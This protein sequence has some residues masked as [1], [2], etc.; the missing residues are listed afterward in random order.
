MHDYVLTTARLVLRCYEPGDVDD[1][2][3][4]ARDPEWSRYLDPIVPSPYSRQDAEEWVASQLSDEQADGIPFVLVLDGVVVGAL[5][6]R[7]DATNRSAELGWSLH[8]DHW[9]RGLT[10]E[11]VHAA[12]DFA[13][14]TR[15]LD[16][17]HARA[18]APNIGS[19]RVMEKVGMTRE[20]VLRLHD[21][22]RYGERHDVVWYGLLRSE[23]ERRGD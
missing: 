12:I 3:A 16:R 11:A 18:F 14:E 23:W 17:V 7:E 15:G 2:Y 8:R 19:W 22:D 4:Y 20:G 5:S 10:T 6:V 1:V 13:F 9:G 21:V